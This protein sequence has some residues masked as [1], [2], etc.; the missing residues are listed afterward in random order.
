MASVPPQESPSTVD[1]PARAR[2]RRTRLYTAASIL[3]AVAAIASLVGGVTY[4]LSGASEGAGPYRLTAGTVVVGLGTGTP[5]VCHVSNLAPGDASTGYPSGTGVADQT[6]AQ[7]RY[8]VKY[9]GTDPAYLAVDVA[10]NN[11]VDNLYTGAA[12]GLQLLVKDSNGT[13]YVGSAAN[14]G[15]TNYTAQSGGAFGSVLANG[16]TASDLLV[17]TSPQTGSP[18]TYTDEFTIDYWMAIPSTNNNIGG[19]TTVTLTFHAAPADNNAPPFSCTSPG[20]G[21]SCTSGMSWS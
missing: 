17:S 10:V 7:C 9:T 11:T 21:V 12:T 8:F 1:I 6:F 13:T 20:A 14:H 16:A 5:V 15:G 18:A 4:G 3:S 2:R 19:N